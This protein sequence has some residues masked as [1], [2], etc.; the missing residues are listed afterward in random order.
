MGTTS[1]SKK[2]KEEPIIDEVDT[3]NGKKMPLKLINKVSKSI[4]KISYNNNGIEC[5]GTGF[6]IV[7]NNSFKCIMTNYHVIKKELINNTITIELYNNKKINIQLYERNL[8]FYDKLDITII[9]IKDSNE[10]IKD[11][12]F[13]DYDLNYVKGYEQYLNVDIFT[14]EYLKGKDICAAS[15]CIKGILNDYEFKHNIDTEFGSSGSPIILFNTLKVIGI[16][17]GGKKNINYGSFIGEIFNDNKNNKNI[18]KN[19]FIIGEIYISKENIGKDIRI[20]NSY[21]DYCREWYYDIE[22]EYKNEKEIKECKIEIN[23]K[24]I[25][26]CYLH[27]FESTGK[28]KIKYTFENNLTKVNYM[29]YKCSSLKN[30]DLSNFDSKNITDMS[31]MFCDCNS[32]TN[33]N[34]LNLNTQNVTNMRSMFYNCSSLTSL[35]LSNFNTK[36]VNNMSEM[37]Y[38]C[39]S[40]INLNLSNFNTQNVTS[41]WCMFSDCSSLT[42]LN[43][44]NF[45]TKNVTDMMSM[46]ANCKSLKMESI[47]TNDS[48]IK[49]Y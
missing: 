33:L 29:F 41:M 15:G 25:S 31:Y 12:K 10:I 37:F 44:L 23:E 45:D 9:E 11:I 6:F 38:N 35:N 13:L 24:K 47:I 21:E 28:Y 32:L 16:H 20:I 18:I 1:T 4:C 7:L 5:N 48:K 36:D 46:F 22:E 43:L 49:L 14:L 17:K 26:F 34:L 8:K 19:N 2:V 27:K 30:L 42:N 39:S 3:G 40:L